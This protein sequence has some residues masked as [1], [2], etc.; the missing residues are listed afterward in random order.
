MTTT[1][2]QSQWVELESL[3]I[4]A[5]HRQQQSQDHFVEADELWCKVHDA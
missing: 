5:I 3:I 2:T 4:Q 1:I